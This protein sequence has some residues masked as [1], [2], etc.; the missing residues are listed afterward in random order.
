MVWNMGAIATHGGDAALK[1]FRQILL[2]S[3]SIQ[4]L[5]QPVYITVAANGREFQEMHADGGA[6][7]PLFFGPAPYLMPN[8]TQKLPATDLYAVING[9]LASEFYMPSR[10]TAAV[11]GRAITVALKAGGRLEL[12]L[13]GLAAKRAGIGFNVTYVG[14]DFD[15]VGRGLFD[16]KYMTA[17]Y[18]YG[19]AKGRADDRFHNAPAIAPSMPP[20][21]SPTASGG[22]APEPASK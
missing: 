16:P 17:L 12:A 13:A 6:T 8:S 20:P 7:G 2:A 14:E 5:F 15:Q 11:L 21:G 3:A 1:L 19:Y 4:G 10:S 22:R 18:D 9:K